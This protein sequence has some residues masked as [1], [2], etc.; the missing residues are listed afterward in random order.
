M[1]GDMSATTAPGRPRLLRSVAYG[2]LALIIFAAGVFVLWYRQHYNI[3]PGQ[4]ATER[5]HWCGRDYQD[6]GAPLKT[7]QQVIAGTYGPVRAFGRYPPLG[8]PGELLYAGVLSGAPPTS[9]AT[10]IY[11]RA[12][13]GK[14]RAYSLLGGP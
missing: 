3:W 9:C 13:P 1:I 7:W 4:D 2:L 6:G 14:Y 5:V 12:G 11:L 10:V 8:I